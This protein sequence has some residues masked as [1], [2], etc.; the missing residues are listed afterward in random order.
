MLAKRLSRAMG[1]QTA[2]QFAGAKAAKI[3][4]PYLRKQRQKLSPE[5]AAL[6]EHWGV[7]YEDLL[8][9]K[10]K[11]QPVRRAKKSSNGHGSKEKEAVG[12]V[13][14]DATSSR[15]VLDQLDTSS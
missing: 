12:T 9:R 7:A 6:C 10:R 3:L 14:F 1:D 15:S 4:R 13:I 8:L 5:C 11:A 2:E